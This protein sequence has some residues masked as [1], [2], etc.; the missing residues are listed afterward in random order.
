MK[1]GRELVLE[2]RIDFSL[3]RHTR[4][5]LKGGGYDQQAKMS[6]PPRAG[7]C[8]TRMFDALVNDFQL[9]GR[10]SVG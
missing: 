10:K 5:I 3:A 9:N 6:L 8:V 4:H 1:T 2:Q 7:A